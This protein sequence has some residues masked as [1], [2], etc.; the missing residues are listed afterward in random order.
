MLAPCAS[1]RTQTGPAGAATRTPSRAERARVPRSEPTSVVH[2]GC[3]RVARDRLAMNSARPVAPRAPRRRL[4]SDRVRPPLY[5]SALVRTPC[6]QLSSRS[7]RRLVFSNATRPPP[8]STAVIHRRRPALGASARGGRR[9]ARRGCRPSPSSSAGGSALARISVRAVR[10]LT[11]AASSAERVDR[12]RPG[13][14]RPRR[15]ARLCHGCAPALPGGCAA[16]G[17]RSRSGCARGTR[18]SR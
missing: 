9:R 13:W 11:P 14:P 18:C 4:R 16:A 6:E 10:L 15:C 8:S 12:A 1:I 17:S 3:D 7:R 5:G 2:L